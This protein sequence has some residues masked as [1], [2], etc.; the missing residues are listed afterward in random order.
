MFNSHMKSQVFLFKTLFVST[1]VPKCLYM[2]CIFEVIDTAQMLGGY[3]FVIFV[4]SSLLHMIL[5]GFLL[6]TIKKKK[7]KTVGNLNN[8]DFIN[9]EM[10]YIRKLVLCIKSLI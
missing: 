6:F 2:P 1:M 3:K 5:L 4:L 10:F 8:D 9:L 7:K